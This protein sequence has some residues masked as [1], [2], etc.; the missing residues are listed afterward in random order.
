MKSF[1]MMLLLPLLSEQ[2]Q[3]S[4]LFTPKTL[5]RDQWYEVATIE[6]SDHKICVNQFLAIDYKKSFWQ[7]VKKEKEVECRQEG[8]DI[9]ERRDHS[10]IS[11]FHKNARGVEI[12]MV[13]KE[14][15][16][17]NWKLWNFKKKS[18]ISLL[19]GN[20]KKHS[21]EFLDKET[22]CQHYN[23]RCEKLVDK[24]CSQCKDGFMPVVGTGC[25]Q[26]SKICV[27]ECG[28]RNQ[29]ACSQGIVSEGNVLNLVCPHQKKGALCRKGL[30][31]FCLNHIVYCK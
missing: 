22:L 5:P 2:I 9:L 16:V 26:H 4:D 25:S 10:E 12:I 14:R 17:W 3:V 29:V 28:G 13:E 23:V 1:L 7:L 27:S 18:L 19:N 11:K 30:T 31:A 8:G 24:D 20:E 15:E 21:S 6:Q